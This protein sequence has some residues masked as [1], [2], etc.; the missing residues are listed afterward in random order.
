MAAKQNRQLKSSPAT[1]L[2]VR[3]T[4]EESSLSDRVYTS[5]G[6]INPSI[7]TPFLPF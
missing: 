3:E 5:Q 1:R 7:T 6:T 4:Q 2:P